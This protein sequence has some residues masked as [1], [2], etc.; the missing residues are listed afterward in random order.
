MDGV[1]CGYKHDLRE[2]VVKVQI[3]IVECTVLFRVQ[4]L[5]KGRG[6][7]SPEVVAHLVYFVQEEH[8]V[9]GLG[10]FQGLD[11]LSRKCSYVCSPVS[12]DFSL[13]THST[14]RNSHE[15]PVE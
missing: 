12:P 6:R 11:Y 3:V 5:Q 10:L 13:I 2:V 8:R 15:L 7:V 14:K 1:G 9:I 4:N